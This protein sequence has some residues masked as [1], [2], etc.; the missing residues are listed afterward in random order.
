MLLA[1]C[2]SSN[3]KRYR[4]EGHVLSVNKAAGFAEIDSKEIPGIMPAMAMQFAVPDANT[5]AK[6]SSGDQITATLV[7]STDGDGGNS[8][9]LENIAVIHK[10][11]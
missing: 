7:V 11:P 1:S 6:L 5:L 8:S 10:A 4:L 3:A 9:H 2:H